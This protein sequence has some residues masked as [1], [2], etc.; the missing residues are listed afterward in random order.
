M[1]KLKGAAPSI[2]FGSAPGPVCHLAL[3]AAS[4][5]LASSCGAIVSSAGGTAHRRSLKE[6]A[7]TPAAREAAAREAA[8]GEAAAREA[9]VSKAEHEE[10]RAEVVELRAEV[11]EL[12]RALAA[13]L[14]S[15]GE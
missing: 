6:A 2:E 9:V 14:A 1:L 11:V 3:D 7:S 8:G 5:Q 12:R 15:H 10:L 13:L 4:G